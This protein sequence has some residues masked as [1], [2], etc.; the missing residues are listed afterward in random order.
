MRIGIV[1]P[2]PAGSSFGNRITALRWSS[3]LKRLGHRVSISQ[4]YDDQAF[5]LLIAL[6]ARRS[7][8]SIKRFHRKHPALPIVVT[9]TG[10]DVYQDLARDE[11]AAKSLEMA[12]RIVALQPKA[13]QRLKPILKAKA[14]VIFQSVETRKRPKRKRRAEDSFVVT[15]IGHLRP[16]KDPFRA[17]QA[18]RLLPSG[19]RICIVQIGAA[20]TAAMSRRAKAELH[21]NPRYQWLG[22]LS[23]ARALSVLSKSDCCVVSSRVEGGANVMSEAIVAGV[24][25]LASRIDGNVGILGADYPGLFKVGDTRALARLFQRVETD[26]HFRAGLRRRVRALAPLFERKREERAWAEL[27]DGLEP[28]DAL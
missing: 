13:L 26:F 10:T 18:T 2:A 9:L 12:T 3:I 25:V 17:A 8:Q 5:D 7:H 6:H 23:R 15:V 20:M 27:I 28:Q 11:R 22:E 4:T 16:V 14:R 24:P 21:N 1:T 19:S